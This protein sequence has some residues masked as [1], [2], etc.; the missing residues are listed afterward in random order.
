MGEGKVTVDD[1][2][3]FACTHYLYAFAGIN[4]DN[5]IK[6][7]DPW[8]DL[9]TGGGLCGYKKFTDM[10]NK[11]AGLLTL[12]SVG[13]WN[14]G[15]PAFSVMA[16]TAATRSVFIMS[17]ISTLRAHNFDG[18]DVS[19]TYPTLNGG[20]PQDKDNFVN[21]L[22]ELE[23]A[24]TSDGMVLT[25]SV[26]PTMEIASQAYHIPSIS[27]YV[28][29][30]SVMTYN[31]HGPWDP[32]TH[33]HSALYPFIN[34]TGNNLYLNA[35]EA[36]RY[37]LISGMPAHKMMLG[38]PMFGR[39]WTLNGVTNT[40]YYAPAS[41]AGPPGPWTSQWGYMSFAEICKA[42]K[43]NGWTIAKEI[44]CNEPYTYHLSSRIWC[45]YEDTES[46]TIKATFAANEGLA[47]LMVWSIND[48]DAHG[49]YT[50]S[51]FNL[52]W[53]LSNTFNAATN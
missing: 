34:D 47:G 3:P 38:V 35:N 20:A 15:S 14:V 27:Q 28:H 29:F 7:N 6:V 23:V 45:S 41:Q 52:T 4:P 13:G 32:Y 39:C 36:I 12:L 25:I 43:A 11:N 5:T 2:D 17:A 37:W 9:C 53:T 46:V 42:Q 1:L 24:M 31:F 30:V 33:H 26:A 49:Y 8:A 48:D 40:G 50:G 16:A 21:L 51:K 10:K 44:G 22:R 19:W 18:L